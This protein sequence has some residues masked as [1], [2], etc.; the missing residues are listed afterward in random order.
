[1][2]C[3]RIEYALTVELL[4]RLSSLQTCILHTPLLSDSIVYFDQGP[5]HGQ[6]VLFKAPHCLI[7]AWH[8]SEIDHAFGAIDAAREAGFWVAGYSSYELG[9]ALEPT[10]QS[11]MPEQRKT[12]LMQF[13]VYAGPD[14]AAAQS[15]SDQSQPDAVRWDAWTPAVSKR[16]YER[17]FNRIHELIIAGDIYQANFT[18][19]LRSA[20][21]GK[22]LDFYFALARNQA[23]KYG[24]YVDLAEGPVL[25]SRSPELFFSLSAEGELTTRP[26]KGTVP[27][28]SDPLEDSDNRQFLQ[29]DEKNRAENLMIVDM[30]RNDLGRIALTGS[31]NVP[32]LFEVEQYETVYQMVSDIRATMRSDVSTRDLFNALHPCGS[33]TG[34][35]KIRAMQVIIDLEQRSRDA[36]CGAIGWLAPDGS[37]RFSVGIRTIS[38]LENNSMQLDVGGGIVYDSHAAGEYEEALWKVRF[39]NPPPSLAP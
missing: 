5:V 39:A 1:M 31:V 23:V 34:A 14:V 8:P 15:L 19:A 13:G 3:T 28:M 18:F 35:P 25:L 12:P 7:T 32:R 17:A 6:P 22:P 9:Y 11:L 38:L 2:R 4:S 21:E 16:D 24:A 37:A 33:I 20:L 27:R 10:L 36:Y 30:L 29:Q 26:M